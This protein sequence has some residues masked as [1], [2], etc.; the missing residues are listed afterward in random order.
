MKS[1]SYMIPALVG[2]ILQY[3]TTLFTALA[4]VRE[5]E[6]GTIEQ[7]IVTPIKSYELVLGKVVP[8]VVIAF[9][10]LGEVLMVGV[11]WF[12]VPIRGS[13]WLLLA[14]AFLFLFTSLGL[15]L[16]ISSAAKTQQEAMFL[17]FF[18]PFAEHISVGLF[19]P[20]GSDA[21]RVTDN[22]L[23]YSATLLPDHCAQY[24]AQRGRIEHVDE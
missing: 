2:I 5:R 6:Q 4:I 13:I 1:S 9:F 11:F 12:G 20:A 3:L 17:S 24:C 21:S 7:L 19:L 16:L 18:Y 14:L 8:Y 15:G 22:Q 23:C 10:D